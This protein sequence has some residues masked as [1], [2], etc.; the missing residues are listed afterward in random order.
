MAGPA[1]TLN[2]GDVGEVNFEAVAAP[3]PSSAW[4]GL[5][6]L[7]GLGLFKLRRNA[8]SPQ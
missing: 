5:A 3:L 2:N 7:V 6:L 4:G 1:I 8:A